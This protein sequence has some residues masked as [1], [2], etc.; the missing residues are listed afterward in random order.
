MKRKLGVIVWVMLVCISFLSAQSKLPKIEEYNGVN[1][2][3][4]N[5]MPYVMLS[6]ELHNSSSSSLKYM[7][8]IWDKLKQMHLNTIIATVSWELF[9]PEEGKYDYTLVEGL[10]KEAR[11]NDFKLVLI[12]FATWKN[13]SSPYVPAWVKKDLN[14]FPRLQD[15]PGNNAEVLTAWGEE[16]MK[17]DAKAYAELMKFIKKIDQK[18]QTVLMMQVQN[19]TGVAIASRDMSPMAERAFRQQVPAELLNSLKDQ[20]ED[21]TPELKLM[22]Q[23]NGNRQSGTWQEMFS[24]G[25]DEVFM[26]WHIG[27]YVGYITDAG[28]KEYNIPMYVN[29]WLDPSYSESIKTD[30]PAGGPVSK[31]LNIWRAAAPGIDLLAPDIYLDDFKRVCAQ[32]A[33]AGNPLFIPETNPDI[34]SAANVYYALGQYNAVCFAPFAIDGF[35]E[36]EAKVLSESYGSLSGFLPF[37][38]K[39]SGKGKNIGFTYTKDRR[40]TFVLGNYRITI[41]YSQARDMENN[42]MESCGLI[43]NTAPD[44]YYITGRNIRVK[45]HPL[46]NEQ[47]HVEIISHDE[48]E[49]VNGVWIPERRMNGDE[50]G[51]RIGNQPKFRLV[52]LYKYL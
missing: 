45:F 31:M 23:H 17:A 35:R 18:E 12:W 46:E 22:M 3:I 13:A 11:K 5:D 33:V 26:A 48:G 2:L 10:I 4:V 19:E 49:F 37:W 16:S 20:K 43:L 8:P 9:E 25:A 41:D 28:K 51:I 40:E 36:H 15:V 42:K 44:E 21:W 14:R 52:K 32:Y 27:K 39:H 50:L 38:A 34:R 47:N 24:Y 7:E 30:Y 1:Q 29:A 6:G